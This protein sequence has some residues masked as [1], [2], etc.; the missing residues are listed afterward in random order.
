M[1]ELNDCA[2]CAKRLQERLRTCGNEQQTEEGTLVQ[3]WKERSRARVFAIRTS[4]ILL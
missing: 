2:Y 3:P 4:V 1:S